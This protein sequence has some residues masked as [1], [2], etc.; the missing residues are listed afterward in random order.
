MPARDLRGYIDDLKEAG[1][2]KEMNQELHWNLEI[3]AIAAMSGITGGP[4]LLFTN[5]KGYKDKGRLGGCL[6]AGPEEQMW[7]RYN[8]ILGLH[9]DTS[10]TDFTYE[11]LARA[12]NPI[13]AT[14]VDSGPCK[15]VI[16]VGE[17]VNLFEFPWPYL[18]SGDGGRYG[19]IN[20]LIIKDIDTDW[21]NWSNYRMLIL[22]KNKL[23]FLL[24]HGQQ[25]GR[26]FYEGWERKGVPMPFA[27]ATG[28]DPC[29]FLAAASYLP[30]GQNEVDLAGGF[31]EAPVELVKCETN[32]LMVPADSEIVIEGEV[33]PG[34]RVDE[35]PFGEYF[36]FIHGPRRPM[37]LFRV[38]CVTYRKNPIIPFVAEGIKGGDGQTVSSCTWCIGITGYLRIIKGYPV[39]RVWMPRETPYNMFVIA[40]EKSDPGLLWEIFDSTFHMSPMGHIDHIA[41]VDADVDPMDIGQFVE[42]F[43]L[44]LHPRKDWHMTEWE[45]P[46]VTLTV[47]LTP[48]ER[49]VGLTK[50]M[51]LDCTTKDEKAEPKRIAFETLY[52]EDTQNWVMNKWENF[53]IPQK[54]VLKKFEDVD[55]FVPTT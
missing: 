22:G 14:L 30:E 13:K 32:N 52:P 1:E 36:G 8:I 39:K 45:M 44:K 7:R 49:K 53:G 11:Y 4:A 38:K 3:P 51:Y 41:F 15:E 27:V 21:V 12:G 46:K 18:H 10:Y 9:P 43:A 48:E 16:K 37:P 19:T 25:G 6:F 17:E 28:G 55:L 31:R 34:E 35:G 26:I 5:I 54:P 40:V 29:Y 23:T 47:Y 42:D 2:L 20:S 50:K 33:R 24:S